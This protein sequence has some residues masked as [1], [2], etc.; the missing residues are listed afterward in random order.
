[1]I[2]CGICSSL[3]NILKV[4]ISSMS[5]SEELLPSKMFFVYA[6]YI[7]KKMRCL[8]DKLPNFQQKPIEISSFKARIRY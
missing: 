6:R 2:S 3:L 1:M 5:D 8:D 7:L 4:Q